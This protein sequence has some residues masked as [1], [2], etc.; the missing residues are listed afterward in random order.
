MKKIILIAIS[1]AL[2]GASVYLVYTNFF[3]G[4]AVDLTPTVDM[5]SVLKLNEQK[6]FPYGGTLDFSVTKKL[7]TAPFNYPTV[8]TQ[9]EVGV[10]GSDL[11]RL[12]KPAQ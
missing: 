11:F 1:V 2:L 6:I 10:S 3:A 5:A 8:N 9:S 7:N 4:D 12:A